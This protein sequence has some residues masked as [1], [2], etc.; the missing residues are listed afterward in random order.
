MESGI[1]CIS[2]KNNGKTYI[3]SS[4]NI[5]KRWVIHLHHLRQGT[6]HSKKL[7][8]SFDK[9]G[10]S[11]FELSV[12]VNLSREHLLQTEQW[13]ID[14]MNPEYNICKSVT[15]G[16]RGLKSSPKHIEAVRKA[17]TGKKCSEET[18][19]K[20]REHNLGKICP[21]YIK[22]K[23]RN[24]GI[25]HPLDSYDS[26]GK[27]VKTFKSIREAS[28]ELGIDNGSIR[29]CISGKYKLAGGFIWKKHG[30]A[31]SVNEIEIR[32]NHTNKKRR[33]IQEMEGECVSSYS[34]I[35]EAARINGFNARKICCC[36]K[37]TVGKYKGFTWRYDNSL[38]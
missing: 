23:L 34:S 36:C 10:E 31:L 13:Y 27:F 2:N 38:M 11:A 1:Y 24:N 6:H 32:N 4:V 30:D 12:I 8:R 28:R 25:C 37:G 18:K 19:K 20:L 26:S 17:N 5:H 33:V 21:E 22:E 35:Q 29:K 9:H 15:N 7:Q 3:G 16:R 14:T